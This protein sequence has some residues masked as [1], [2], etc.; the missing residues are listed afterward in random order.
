M[1]K[2]WQIKSN[3]TGLSVEALFGLLIHLKRLE[4]KKG[5][6]VKVHQILP[7]TPTINTSGI[8]TAQ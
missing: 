3:A 7:L 8:R 1:I 6:V 4:I 2:V 5:K